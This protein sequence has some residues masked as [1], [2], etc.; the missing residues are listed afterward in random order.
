MGR[1]SKSISEGGYPASLAGA[2]FKPVKCCGKSREKNYYIRLYIVK[3]ERG[4]GPVSCGST[5]ALIA[6]ATDERYLIY[7]NMYIEK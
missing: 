4:V 7:T 6:T 1:E 3:R 5:Y 2:G